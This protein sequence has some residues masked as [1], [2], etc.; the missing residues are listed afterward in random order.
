MKKGEKCRKHPS[1]GDCGDFCRKVK[2]DE[3]VY[4]KGKVGTKPGK[5]AGSLKCDY[6]MYYFRM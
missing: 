1:L 2:I 5:M 3:E 4:E 6:V